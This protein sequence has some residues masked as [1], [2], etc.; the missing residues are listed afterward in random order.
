MARPKSEVTK[1]ILSLPVEVSAAEV[2]RLAAAQG[3]ATTDFNVYRVRRLARQARDAAAKKRSGITSASRKGVV[4]NATTPTKKP[5]LAPLSKSDF[6]RSQPAAATTAEVV[7]A[8]KA[9]GITL[10]PHL[11]YKVRSR[12]TPRNAPATTAA[13]AS[14]RGARGASGVPADQAVQ[15][16]PSPAT[17]P[18]ASREGGAATSTL[19][20]LD[21]ILRA[22]ADE[23]VRR[24][25]VA[26]EALRTALAGYEAVLVDAAK[27]RVV[28]KVAAALGAEPPEVPDASQARRAL[29]A[30]IDA[31]SIVLRPVQASSRESEDTSAVGR[32]E[33]LPEPPPREVTADG[34]ALLALAAPL[35]DQVAD[36]PGGDPAGLNDGDH[37]SPSP[38]LPV[39]EERSVPLSKE[40]VRAYFETLAAAPVPASPRP[41]SSW[42]RERDVLSALLEQ[43]GPIVD[44]RTDA[45]SIEELDMLDAITADTTP[46]TDLS[47]SV[48]HLWLS[49]LVAR[50]RR[51]KDWIAVNYSP[52][53][54]RMHDIIV[55]LPTFAHEARP[56]HVN[57]MRSDHVPTRSSWEADASAYLEELRAL[58]CPELAVPSATV[59]IARTPPKKKSRERQDPVGL[60][61]PLRERV[62][63]MRMV[64]FGGEPREE[65]RQNLERVL[66]IGALEWPESNK[67]RRLDAL[68]GSI[69]SGKHDVVLVL[70]RFVDHAQSAK[71][72]DAARAHGTPYA[73][74]DT[75]YGVAQV[76]QAIEAALDAPMI[77]VTR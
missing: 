31:F 19:P 5:N 22:A 74:V 26:I 39:E 13:E 30:A 24:E 62:R 32:A 70:R 27:A 41:S 6:I 69:A 67:P 9:A 46:W 77:S 51:L 63:G 35:E 16:R 11:V 76:R 65:A 21:D 59:P 58:V 25:T 52:A 12:L 43:A 1:F 56:A 42:E 53:K 68:V 60:D 73:L 64:L 66:G 50:A 17:G 38:P 7:Q 75:G 49:F 47:R 10:D 44:L 28:A 54:K 2:V 57:G 20:R 72:I 8:A 4:R 29:I 55:R 18:M 34:P 61:W 3:F 14:S 40:E 36:A 48:Q 23:E 33:E 45:S 71:L 37:A 15:H